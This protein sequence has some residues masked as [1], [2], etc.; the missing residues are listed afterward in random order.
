M[1]HFLPQ[2]EDLSRISFP[3]FPV[4][5]EPGGI[6]T[7]NTLALH[8]LGGSAV[9]VAEECLVQV[10]LKGAGLHGLCDSS[11]HSTQIH[12]E[13]ILNQTA[14]CGSARP[15]HHLPIVLPLFEVSRKSM[16][17]T[18]IISPRLIRQYTGPYLQLHQIKAHTCT[19]TEAH[20]DSRMIC[21]A[22]ALKVMSW[23][24]FDVTAV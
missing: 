9:R 11:P 24:I 2:G 14:Q 19:N 4:T 6:L 17:L 15:A 10:T 20:T 22:E 12:R 18:T 1:N 3:F 23:N 13:N 21:H 5:V 16:A 8:R 7:E